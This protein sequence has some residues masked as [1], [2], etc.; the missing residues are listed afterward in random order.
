MS[1]PNN[2]N[3][4]YATINHI[5]NIY[6]VHMSSMLYSFSYYNTVIRVVIILSLHAYVDYGISYIIFAGS[7]G[8]A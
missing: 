8:I 3:M 5:Y 2:D 7:G 1:T 4:M 6:V